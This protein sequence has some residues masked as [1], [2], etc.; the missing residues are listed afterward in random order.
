ME[1][2]HL[3]EDSP[4]VQQGG[5]QADIFARY[6]DALHAEALP[7]PEGSILTVRCTLAEDAPGGFWAFL[8]D[9][10]VLDFLVP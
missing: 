2:Y 7:A 8:V 6:C 10:R 5:L 3:D 9:S 4:L 1:T